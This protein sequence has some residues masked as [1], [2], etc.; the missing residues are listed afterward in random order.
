MPDPKAKTHPDKAALLPAAKLEGLARLDL[1]VGVDR[2]RLHRSTQRRKRQGRGHQRGGT[3]NLEQHHTALLC[4]F[5][6]RTE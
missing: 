2:P 1:E 6:I 4:A 5:P 3:D